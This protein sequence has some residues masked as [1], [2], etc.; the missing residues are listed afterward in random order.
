MGS[1]VEPERVAFDAVRGW[2]LESIRLA[3]D[4]SADR[5]A[6]QKGDPYDVVT[7]M[8]G[9]IERY[10]RDQVRAGFPDHGFLGEEE[11]GADDRVGWQWV[12][13]PIDGTLNYSTGMAGSACSIAC[14]RDGELVIGMIADYTT[15]LAYRALAGSGSI[16]VGDERGETQA[17][18]STSRAGAARVFLEFGW[19][20]LDPV[21]LG[22]MTALSE[23]RLRVIRM[24]GGAAIA[25][26]NVAMYGGCLLGIGLRI[27]DVAAGIVLA[28]EAGRT[29]RVWDRGSTIHLIVGTAEDVE[30]LSPIVERFGA[31]R[32]APV[33]G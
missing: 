10:L 13:D 26:L 31:A 33:A 28:R 2:A 11:G 5:E 15:G 25:L 7:R 3:R 16:L 4:A 12:V 18:P 30:E 21:T 22:V 27:W 8:D 19:E 23:L 1:A 32:V 24:I 14:R 9:L 6:T 17:I 20:D 29:V